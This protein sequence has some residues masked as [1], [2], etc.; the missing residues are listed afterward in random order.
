MKFVAGMMVVFAFF[1]MPLI[2]QTPA[3][4]TSLEEALH[5]PKAVQVLDLSDQGLSEVPAAL[6]DLPHLEQLNLSFNHFKTIPAVVFRCKKLHTLR[7]VGARNYIEHLNRQESLLEIIPPEIE[8]LKNLQVLDLSYNNIRRLPPEFGYLSKLSQLDFFFNELDWRSLNILSFLPRL[9]V[10]NVGGN[11]LTALPERWEKLTRLRFLY[12]DNRWV[13]G[14]PAGEPLAH[15]PEVIFQLR[16][17]ETLSLAGQFI[18]QIPPTISHLRRLKS[19]NLYNNIFADL[20]DDFTKLTRLESLN[21]GMLC[22]GSISNYCQEPFVF[23][24]DMC[25]LQQ[26]KKLNTQS[27]YIPEQELSKISCLEQLTIR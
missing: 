6:A 24:E 2:A 13:E 22:L 25:R 10:L 11:N 8:Q 17:L 7:I 9:T 12:L 1:G 3:V 23:P 16:H 15:F 4:F 26:L 20:P 19:L 5:N 18:P 14:V 21:I 27:R